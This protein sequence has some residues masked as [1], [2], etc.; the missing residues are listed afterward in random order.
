MGNELDKPTSSIS[1]YA[2]FPNPGRELVAN[3]YVDVLVVKTYGD[4]VRVRQSYVT[5]EN[6]GAYVYTVQNGK[7]NK[8]PVE[9][10]TVSGNDYLLKNTFAAGE[11]IV[12]DKV[13]RI[14]EGQKIKTR[15]I[16]AENGEKK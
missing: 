14:A 9:I 16:G 8:K 7:L 3:A 11:Y 10:V 1:V 13:G 5:L 4:V 6:K 2:D 12:V 15:L